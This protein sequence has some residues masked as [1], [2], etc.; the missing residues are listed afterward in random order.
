MSITP[1][2]SPVR[3]NLAGKTH[4]LSLAICLGLCACQ[5]P[6]TGSA[7]T[8]DD[9]ASSPAPAAAPA[10]PAESTLGAAAPPASPGAAVVDDDASRQRPDDSYRRADLRPGYSTCV[11]ASGGNTFEMQAC[12][13]EELA[14]HRDLVRKA[15]AAVS[16]RPDSKDKDDWMDAQAAWVE[17]TDSHCSWDQATEGQGQMLDAQSCRINRFANRAKELQPLLSQP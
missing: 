16:A 4:W 5:A 1:I 13:D 2:Q 14:Y 15:V 10:I 17:Q 7:R 9:R 8:T 6:A 12:G 11:D 3:R